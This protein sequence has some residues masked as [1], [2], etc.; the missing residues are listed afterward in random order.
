VSLNRATVTVVVP[1]TGR[2][3]L[4]TRALDT[5]LRQRAVDVRAIVAVDGPADSPPSDCHLDDGCVSV[6]WLPERRG[7]AAARNAGLDAVRTAW[8][9][10]LDDDDL[11]APDK[12]HRQ[13][14]AAEAAQAQLVY[15]SACIVDAELRLLSVVTAPDPAGLASAL[16]SANEIPAAA[17]NVLVRTEA[18]MDAG[19]FDLQF[20][21]FADWD[22]WLRL[23]DSVPIAA[24]PDV[25]VA[26]VQHSR[27]MVAGDSRKLFA[28]YARFRRK[29]ESRG[30]GLHDGH[31]VSWYA[32]RHRL[33]RNPRRAGWTALEGG[34]RL[35][36]PGAALRG[37]AELLAPSTVARARDR[38][39]VP[40]SQAPPAWL[41]AIRQRQP[42][43]PRINC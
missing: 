37:A 7:V 32:E 3:P 9:A 23:V 27:N 30:S 25:L 28:E 17:S 22:L 20:Q 41:P 31:F 12:L 13:L 26:Y 39:R 36:R 4:V 15:A 6:V 40:T 11:W 1:T 38:R 35:G 21:H 29:H 18:L 10:F 42:V 2:W 14:A 34:L 33:A 24:V 16:A 5:I 8:T 19:G 43:P